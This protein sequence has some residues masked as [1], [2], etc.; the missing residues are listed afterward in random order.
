MSSGMQRR[1]QAAK[2]TATEVTKEWTWKGGA[3]EETSP[4]GGKMT[5][6]ECEGRE[7]ECKCSKLR[8]RKVRQTGR[9]NECDEK[10]R[11]RERRGGPK[12]ATDPRGGRAAV[13]RDR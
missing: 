13:A 7:C 11:E 12:P 10:R 5:I 8:C 9:Q 2:A 4:G 3:T 6:N 1:K